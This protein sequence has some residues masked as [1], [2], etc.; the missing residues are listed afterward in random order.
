M[1]D[2]SRINKPLH[3]KRIMVTKEDGREHHGKVILDDGTH[4]PEWAIVNTIQLFEL[5][6]VERFTLKTGQNFKYVSRC[7][8][9]Q[10]ATHWFNLMENEFPSVKWSNLKEV[11]DL[12]FLG[13]SILRW[14]TKWKKPFVMENKDY[15]HRRDM[16]YK[17]DAGKYTRESIAVPGDIEKKDLYFYAR[18]KPHQEVFADRY[19]RLQ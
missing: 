8:T 18:A 11:A 6:L 15:V 9:G 4:G 14:I 16:L 10:A 1:I 7:V 17:Y 3:V 13:G 5:E 19:G 12:Q 2:K